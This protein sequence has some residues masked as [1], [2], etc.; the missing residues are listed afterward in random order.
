[1]ACFDASRANS[2][3]WWQNAIEMQSLDLSHRLYMCVYDQ[4]GVVLLCAF[5]ANITKH[6]SIEHRVGEQ[7]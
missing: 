5:H 2:H 7:R 1:M 3:D 6:K 4:I